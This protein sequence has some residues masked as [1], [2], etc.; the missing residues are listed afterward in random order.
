MDKLL[1]SMKSLVGYDPNMEEFVVALL[2][3]ARSE[4]WNSRDKEEGTRYEI[5]YWGDRDDERDGET[6]L[7]EGEAW[8]DQVWHK[9][10]DASS[11]SDAS[12]T[13]YRWGC[14]WR[15]IRHNP[16]LSEI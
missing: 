7:A 8:D 13:A 14:D 9:S 3:K 4:G 1:E 16:F 10:R 6:E 11:A 12:D 15:A 5:G 2:S